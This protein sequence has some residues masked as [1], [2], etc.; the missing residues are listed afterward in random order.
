M[1]NTPKRTTTLLEPVS[2]IDNEEPVTSP[3][4]AKAKPSYTFI[5]KI[6]V[7]RH[8]IN[9]HAD[10]P[11]PKKT[12]LNRSMSKNFKQTLIPSPSKKISVVAS[13]DKGP[14]Q[15]VVTQSG[16]A[17]SDDKL[18][19]GSLSVEECEDEKDSPSKPPHISFMSQVPKTRHSIAATG[20][21]SKEMVQN[22][23]KSLDRNF[24]S[25]ATKE[26]VKQDEKDP[27]EDDENS[28][29]GDGDVNSE[30][31][32]IQSEDE[33]IQPEDE[34]SQNSDNSDSEN[35]DDEADS[36]DESPEDGKQHPAIQDDSNNNTKAS[37]NVSDI[38]NRCQNFLITRTSE[39]AESRVVD[40][41]KQQKKKERKELKAKRQAEERKRKEELL[42]KQKA[43]KILMDLKN[44]QQ[45]EKKRTEPK[46]PQIKA[47]NGDSEAKAAG[48]KVNSQSLNVLKKLDMLLTSNS[49]AGKKMKRAEGEQ[50]NDPPKKKL[51]ILDAEITS[52]ISAQLKK[53]KTTKDSVKNPEFGMETKLNQLAK[54]QRKEHQK[55]KDAIKKKDGRKGKRPVVKEPLRVL[56][57][58]VWTSSGL[59]QVEE[60]GS[61]IKV[62]K[63]FNV[64]ITSTDHI[65]RKPNFKEEFLNRK[66]IR[67]GPS[68]KLKKFFK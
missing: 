18:S 5:D 48:R 68:Q 37:S 28:I 67:R 45:V 20:R 46:P 2:E 52:Q 53:P 24:K 16:E 62:K 4:N 14:E 34:L 7:K 10:A 8:S 3:V 12:D 15:E 47:V 35:D 43:Q 27:S 22:L 56:P 42:E 64:E 40:E 17:E 51:K 59:F 32:Q 63:G 13:E 9:T 66:D 21:P 61:P 31:E 26:P 65:G 30:D 39:K 60:A 6:P 54:G 25:K 29:E 11:S 49:G 38:L 57:K 36:V 55:F 23:N 50:E 1:C 33:Q 41:E 19:I 44:R 58:P